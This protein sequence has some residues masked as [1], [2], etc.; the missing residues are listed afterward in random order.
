MVKFILKTIKLFVQ[1]V[2]LIKLMMMDITNEY[3]IFFHIGERICFIKTYKCPKC[4]KKFVTN[5]KSIV[6][7]NKNITKPVI[8][9]I[10]NLYS[11]FGNSIYKNQIL[12]KKKTITSISHTKVLKT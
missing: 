4:G 6:D 2:N 5:M 12:V 11:I 3:W 1:D 8:D 10:Q 9:C 7:E